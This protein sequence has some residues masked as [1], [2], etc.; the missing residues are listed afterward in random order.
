[1][2]F[3]PVEREILLR[4]AKTSITYGLEHHTPMVVTLE[5]YPTSLH[6]TRSCFVTLHANGK[7]RGC[8]GSLIATEA[9]AIN[10]AQNAYNAAFADP[11]FKPL[12]PEEFK[13]VV[14]DISVLSQPRAMPVTSEADL[15]QKLQPGVH[16]L[17]L[18]DQGK[19]ATFLPSV[20]QQLPKP[21]DFVNHLKNKAGWPSNYWS[22]TMSVETY[23][24]ELIA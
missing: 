23:T 19:H 3:G 10:V 2:T 11:R 22:N 17:I 18:S 21:V 14:L 9:L 8:V 13:T 15:L 7:L 1:M 5:N 4:I 20:W 16:G 6:V 12:T 24:A